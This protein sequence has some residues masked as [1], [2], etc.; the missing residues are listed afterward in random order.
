MPL[1]GLVMN[2]SGWPDTLGFIAWS[3]LVFTMVKPYFHRKH[4]VPTSQEK[5]YKL[6]ERFG[7]SPVDH[8]KTYRDK[9]FYFSDQFEAFIAYRIANGFAIVLEEPVCAD[10]YK[11]RC[12]RNL[13]GIVKRWV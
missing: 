8:F 13:K 11:I 9:L 7:N 2:L 1:P 12:S 4:H 5:A 10:D 6:V 3:F